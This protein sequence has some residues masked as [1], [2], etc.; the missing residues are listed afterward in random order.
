MIVQMSQVLNFILNSLQTVAT[1]NEDNIR[2][3]RVLFIPVY[4]N[5]MRGLEV[6]SSGGN[7]TKHQKQGVLGADKVYI[8]CNFFD[9]N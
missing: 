5:S 9:A 2:K 1:S 4:F 6:R 8:S 3:L 7:K